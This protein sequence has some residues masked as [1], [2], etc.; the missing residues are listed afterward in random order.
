VLTDPT[1]VSTRVQVLSAARDLG[2]ETVQFEA[3]T[4][5][6]I[7]RALD[8]ITAAKFQAVNVLASPLLN[9]SRI[10]IID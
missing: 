4:P 3:Q 6:E 8:A 5:D 7:G 10:Q 2:V 1:T 9:L